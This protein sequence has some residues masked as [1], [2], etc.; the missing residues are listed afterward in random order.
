LE[1]CWS[2]SGGGGRRNSVTAHSE[3]V[4]SALVAVLSGFA[5]PFKSFTLVLVGTHTDLRE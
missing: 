4:L 1:G 2:G 3:T 5:E